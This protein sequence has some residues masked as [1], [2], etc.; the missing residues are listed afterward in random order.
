MYFRENSLKTTSF[1]S[2]LGGEGFQSQIYIGIS[3]LLVV[4]MHENTP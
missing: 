1:S 2:I 4:E 3:L